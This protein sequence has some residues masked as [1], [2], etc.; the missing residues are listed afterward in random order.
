MHADEVDKWVSNPDVPPFKPLMGECEAPVCQTYLSP[1]CAPSAYHEQLRI[2][3]GIGSEAYRSSFGIPEDKGLTWEMQFMRERILATSSSGSSSRYQR[4]I[5][6]IVQ[7]KYHSLLS[8]DAKPLPSHSDALGYRTCVYKALSVMDPFVYCLRRVEGFRLSNFDLVQEAIEKWSEVRHPNI[9]SVR[10]AFA[11]SEFQDLE[12]VGEGG[13]L[14]YVYDYI[15]LAQTLDNWQEANE[16]KPVNEMLLWEIILQCCCALRLIHSKSLSARCALD[17][18]KILISSRFRVHLNC[19][20][21]LDAIQ[22]RA[23]LGHPTGTHSREVLMQQDLVNLGKTLIS[24][25]VGLKVQALPIES[26]IPQIVQ[27]ASA[28]KVISNN[29]RL[30]ILE[31][32]SSVESATGASKVL[33]MCGAYTAYKVEQ[34]TSA[35]D[36]LMH[37]LRKTI[38]TSRLYKVMMKINSITERTHLLNDYRWATTGDR[39]IVQLFRDYAFFQNDETGR[40]F[41]DAGH[42]TDCLAKVDVGSFESIMLMSRDSQSIIVTNYSDIK[43]CIENCYRELAEAA[44]K[45]HPPHIFPPIRP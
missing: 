11:T 5:P 44:P 7:N 26:E 31:L 30:V 37:E 28:E 41:L 36:V 6:E 4:V 9:V 25:A 38:D 35:Q 15:D 29:M 13:S 42:I 18:S 43:R 10:Q 21:L 16:Y 39:Y 33:A 23:I 27:Q 19:V 24:L 14:V 8:L 1:Q 40:P 20:G 2:V 12:G 17:P 45:A 22:H 3:T 34:L 32:L